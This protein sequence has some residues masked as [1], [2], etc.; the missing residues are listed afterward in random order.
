MFSNQL[1][2]I[3]YVKK[4]TIQE[5][6]GF[7]TMDVSQLSDVSLEESLNNLRLK[8]GVLMFSLLYLTI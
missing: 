5:S 7:Q 6:K 2:K 8:S 3:W 1:H 4:L